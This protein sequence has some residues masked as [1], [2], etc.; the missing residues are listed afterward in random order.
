MAR[1]HSIPPI[2]QIY[3][4]DGAVR[5]K[6]WE[7]IVTFVAGVAVTVAGIMI[8]CNVSEAAKEI[9]QKCLGM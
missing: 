7:G 3:K 9:I 2:L 6:F 5:M 1:T 8:A 4:T